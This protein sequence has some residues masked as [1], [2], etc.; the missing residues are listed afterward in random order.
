MRETGSEMTWSTNRGTDRS[1]W[2]QDLSPGLSTPK[3]RLCPAGPTPAPGTVGGI[4]Q[5]DLLKAP[6]AGCPVEFQEWRVTRFDV[7]FLTI[8]DHP[9]RRFA[10]GEYHFSSLSGKGRA[11][12]PNKF[13]ILTCELWIHSDKGNSPAVQWVRTRDL[14]HC[15]PGSVLDQGTDIP[16]SK[17]CIMVKKKDTKNS[18]WQ[19]SKIWKLGLSALVSALHQI[20][21][22]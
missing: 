4:A 22:I 18:K 2:T 15:D 1:W 20:K 21:E 16:S 7:S 17:P 12:H 10:G 14:H 19:F 11:V 8:T 9:S 13:S 6:E 5:R 3:S